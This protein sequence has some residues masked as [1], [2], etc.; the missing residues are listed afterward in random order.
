[1][2][3]CV[4]RDEKKAQNKIYYFDVTG[5]KNNLVYGYLYRLDVS[6]YLHTP[7]C[8]GLHDP[9][10][11]LSVRTLTKIPKVEILHFTRWMSWSP[12]GG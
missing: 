1:M 4:C 8:I 3:N 12:N 9:Y 7:F 10:R 5:D 6:Q 2:S 11:Y